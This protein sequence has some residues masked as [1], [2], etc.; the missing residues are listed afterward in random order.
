MPQ[1]AQPVDKPL[2]LLMQGPTRSKEAVR[3]KMKEKSRKKKKTMKRK[4]FPCWR[5]RIRVKHFSL[6][7]GIK[8]LIYVSESS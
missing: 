6:Q 5:E 7:P 8:W 4:V 3:K 1:A 2:T